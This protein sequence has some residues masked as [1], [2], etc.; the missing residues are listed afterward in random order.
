VTVR[1]VPRTRADPFPLNNLQVQL[2]A[3]ALL[4]VEA[5]DRDLLAP[6]AYVPSH[7]CSAWSDAL[8]PALSDLVL[9][10]LW[11]DRRAQLRPAAVLRA[12]VSLERGYRRRRAD[13]PD[14]W[15]RLPLVHERTSLMETPLGPLLL[16]LAAWLGTCGGCTVTPD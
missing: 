10:E 9:V 12:P 7:V 16:S 11:D 8:F 14:P 13:A 1:L 6:R 15:A 3:G 2:L 5:P 4:A